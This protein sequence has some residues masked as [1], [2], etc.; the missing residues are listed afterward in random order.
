[1]NQF[2]TAFW[3]TLLTL[4][5]VWAGRAL[6]GQH[7]MLIALTFAIVSNLGA[8]F[9]SDSIVLAMYG[10][11]VVSREEAPQL[12]S[13]V[14]QLAQAGGIPGPRIAIIDTPAMNAFAT[15]RNP[16]HAVVAVT[17]GVLNVLTRDELAGVLGHEL[18]HVINRDIL[19]GSIAA[20]LAGVISSLASMAKWAMIFG[21][22]RSSD[23]DEDSSAGPSIF[24]ILALPFIAFL[25]QGAVSRSRE[26]LA[27]E[28]GARLSGR[29]MALASALQKLEMAASQMPLDASPATAHMFIV[30]PLTG[31]GMLRF[32]S[33]HP[34][35]ADRIEALQRLAMQMGTGC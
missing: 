1:M 11:K 30:N 26:F 14:E 33:T 25:I 31:G 5:V 12:H 28:A 2:K 3:M 23:S 15:G 34:T 27:D 22:S 32:L 35:T 6:G 4:L 8:Y 19:I 24:A 21:S 13:I 18:G 17:T 7:G 29:P 9:F 10:A 20:V 16:D